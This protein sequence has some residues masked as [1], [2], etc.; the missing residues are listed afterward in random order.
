MSNV[1]DDGRM[2]RLGQTDLVACRIGI[3]CGNEL[4]GPLLEYA[5]SRG[6]NYIFQSSDFHAVTYSNSWETIRNTWGLRSSCRSEVIFV[7][8]S[9]VCDAEKILGVVLDQL[10]A[11]RL[12]YLD[13]FQWGW[14]TRANHLPHILQ[15]GRALTKENPGMSSLVKT[16]T[17]VA[18]QVQDEL[19]AR[20][21]ARYVGVSTH[22]RSLAREIV[23]GNLADVLML[24]YN[25]A[26]RGAEDEVFAHAGDRRPGVVA[27]NV[28]HSSV[29][30]NSAPPGLPDGKYV[31]SRPDLYRWALDNPAVDVV[32]TG[33]N[34]KEQIDEALSTLE[35]PPL[36][37]A[38]HAYLKKFGDLHAGT[39]RLAKN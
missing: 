17:T 5:V 20:G 27:F 24:R 25:V 31:P 32:L 38:V 2:V 39:V 6:I 30:L 8:C 16:Y 1:T 15:T 10:M 33:P 4:T 26:H 37:P 11:W 14:V 9:Y 35:Q 36:D 29:P 22:D 21:Y 18:G 19:R 34:S 12:D 7:G 28:G 23:S 3:G 13:V